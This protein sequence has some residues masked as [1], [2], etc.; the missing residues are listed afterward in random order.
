MAHGDTAKRKLLKELNES[1]I[2][3]M[4]CKKSGVHRS[5]YY[6]WLKYDEEFEEAARVAID[7]SSGKVSDLAVS[8]LISLIQEKDFRA[9]IYWLSRRHPDF[10][11]QPIK[12]RT[13]RHMIDPSE[14][15]LKA[16]GL[17]AKNKDGKK[18]NR[19]M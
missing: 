7:A 19:F 11:T 4:A 1:P 18:R 13:G 2:I 12:R 8:Q 15:V 10:A 5:S 9:I 16:F 6:R 3:E 17:L 14:A